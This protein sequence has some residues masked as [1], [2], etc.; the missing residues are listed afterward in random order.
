MVG[1]AVEALRRLGRDGRGVEDSIS[2]SLGHRIRIEIRAA[3]HEG[4]ATVSQLAEIVRQPASTV[5]HHIKEMRKDGSIDIAKT[6]KVG[7]MDVHYYCVVKLPFFSDEDVAAMTIADR[8]ALYAMIVQAASAEALASLWAGKMARDPRA[9]LAWNRI[10]LDRQG[11]DE[12]AE[13]EIASWRRKHEIEV[14]STNRRAE[15]GNDGATYVIV[16]FGFER[17]RTAA[18]IPLDDNREADYFRAPG[19]NRLQGDFRHASS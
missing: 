13:E 9:M 8:Q 14:R 3:L 7:N 1:K 6:K 5:E 4:P 17:S 12:L 19:E 16:S 18:P 11:R 2:Y 15:S 10:N